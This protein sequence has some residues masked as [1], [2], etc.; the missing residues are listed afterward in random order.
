MPVNFHQ[1][2]NTCTKLLMRMAMNLALLLW[3]PLIPRGAS[4]TSALISCNSHRA[5]MM[6]LPALL[7]GLACMTTSPQSAYVS[8]VQF[9]CKTSVQ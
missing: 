7:F 1:A 9:C 5:V 2:S 3:R 4:F 8:W 6:K